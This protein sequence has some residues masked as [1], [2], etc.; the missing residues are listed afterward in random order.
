MAGSVDNA[1]GVE[2]LRNQVV[3]RS[4][5]WLVASPRLGSEVEVI[6]DWVRLRSG[7]YLEPTRFTTSTVRAHYTGGFDLAL[8]VWN[9]FG[10]WPDDYRWRI[11]AA[12]TSRVTFRP[13]ASRSRLVPAS[14]GQGRA[15]L[16]TRNGCRGL[17][18][19]RVK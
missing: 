15:T 9:V 18:R 8:G 3:N 12:S 7:V 16:R 10:L 13:S 14:P 1:V 19:R 6:P 17:S 5:E 11:G 2:S 4:G